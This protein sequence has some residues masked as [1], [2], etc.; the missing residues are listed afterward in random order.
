M[1]IRTPRLFLRPA[2]PEDAAVVHAAL[3]DWDIARQLARVPWPYT[4]ADAEAFC[5]G[6][7]LG[8]GEVSLLIWRRTEGAPTLVGCMGIHA[9]RGGPEIG[10]WLARAAWGHGY[11]VEAGHAMLAL[12]FEGLGHTMLGAGHYAGNDASGRV[13]KRLGFTPTG[14]VIPY[15]CV[16]RGCEVDSVEFR[17]TREDWTAR[18]LDALAA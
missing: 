7:V 13:L 12:A 3:D 14:E 9:A 18:H 16:A 4:R 6:R 2:W 5:A 8:E 11:A 1:F 15:P 17:L 10:Y